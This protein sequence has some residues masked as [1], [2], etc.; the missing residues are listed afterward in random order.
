MEENKK[1]KNKRIKKSLEL[2]NKKKSIGIHPF[3][4]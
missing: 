1:H 3:E 4:T 2:L